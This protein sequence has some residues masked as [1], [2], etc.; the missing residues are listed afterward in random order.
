MRSRQPTLWSAKHGAERAAGHAHGR[1]NLC[2]T[3]WMEAG[4]EPPHVPSARGSR[5]SGWRPN[6]CGSATQRSQPCSSS[7][8][9][10]LA[11][12]LTASRG[13]TPASL[14][15]RPPRAAERTVV[16][17]LHHENGSGQIVNHASAVAF[18]P[19]GPSIA[20]RGPL[21]L[22][23]AWVLKQGNRGLQDI[24]PQQASKSLVT[25]QTLPGGIVLQFLFG[26]NGLNR[27]TKSTVAQYSS[28]I[29]GRRL[30]VGEESV[31]AAVKHEVLRTEDRAMMTRRAR[32]R[33]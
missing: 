7:E 5:R 2:R 1:A 3:C 4:N 28:S 11:R 14:S 19:A 23:L 17:V 31:L 8:P 30:I 13:C 33:G 24:R 32:R 15:A 20:S 27:W 25:R 6:P 26:F 16:A 12:L 29:R 10:P 21:V 22:L 18:C 9:R